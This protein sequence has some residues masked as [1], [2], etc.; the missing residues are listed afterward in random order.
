LS[1]DGTIRL[2]NLVT[3]TEEI[4]IQTNTRPLYS[5]ALSPD[6]SLLAAGGE[7]GFL[8][9]WD[10]DWDNSTINERAM[11]PDFDGSVSA[12]AFS[13]DGNTLALSG[14]LLL[15]IHD[16]TEPIPGAPT[17]ETHSLSFSPDGNTLVAGDWD[18]SVRAWTV[19]GNNLTEERVLYSRSR[20]SPREIVIV[21]DI[22][23]NGDGSV[24]AT[25][26]GGEVFLS[27]IETDEILASLP[28]GEGGVS[29]SPDNT[30]LAVGDVDGAISLYGV[31]TDE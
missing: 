12:L 22:A 21:G 31:P 6:Q 3:R 2:W 16:M 17:G 5:L 9:L 30:L 14:I 27:G 8:G 18:G 25:I 11:I 19:E 28:G 7:D 1:R 4:V 15:N 24:V 26:G 23:F 13:P 20:H 29:F 10:V